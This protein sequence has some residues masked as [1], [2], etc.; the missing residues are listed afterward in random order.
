MAKEEKQEPLEIISSIIDD[1]LRELPE[2][3]Q[4]ARLKAANAEASRALSAY[5]RSPSD[6]TERSRRDADLHP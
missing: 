3:E 6:K 2:Q 1:S 4:L 5:N